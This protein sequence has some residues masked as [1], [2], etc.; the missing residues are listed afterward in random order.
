DNAGLSPACPGRDVM[1]ECDQDNIRFDMTSMTKHPWSAQK[2]HQQ[3]CIFDKVYHPVNALTLHAAYQ[4]IDTDTDANEQYQH[5]GQG[6]A[7]IKKSIVVAHNASASP[8]LFCKKGA[9]LCPFL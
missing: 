8:V 1:R 7:K 9:Q 2:R 4:H 6:T 3:Q 5:P